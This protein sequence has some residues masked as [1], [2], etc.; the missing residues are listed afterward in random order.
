MSRRATTWLLTVALLIGGTAVGI[1]AQ[2]AEEDEEARA[3]RSE[4]QRTLEMVA[5]MVRAR[6]ASA[7]GWLGVRVEDVDDARAEEL[8][9]TGP[10]GAM[11]AGVEEESPAAEA[12]LREGDVIVSFDGEAVR[13]VAELV[14]LVRE[15]PTGRSVP[16]EVMRD[17]ERRSLSATVGDRPGPRAFRFR[18]GPDGMEDVELRL[19][20]LGERLS[21]E[22]MARV[23]ER[24]ERA[25]ERAREHAE[26]FEFDLE[27]GDVHVFR[28]S[29]RPR[30][31]VQLQSLTDQLAEYFGVSERGG[32]L[33]SA[34]RDGSP[35]S[36]AGLRAGDVVV[37][38]DGEEIEDAGDLMRAV[39]EAE[40][41]SATVTVVRRGQER[42]ITVEL[43]EEDRAEPEEEGA[44]GRRAPA[45][46][47][48]PARAGVRSP[49]PAPP[50]AVPAPP[51]LRRAAPPGPRPPV[52]VI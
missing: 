3:E 26:D 7:G 47:P 30:L 16:V 44:T 52:I 35:A 10:R 21:G 39:R 5:P 36:A 24:V 13:S 28:V 20:R 31:G 17:G 50:R 8:G 37:A 2:E 45:G 14:R 1:R 42:E 41:G 15:T 49:R 23:H 4:R 34:V 27:D 43:P 38:F 9:L 46:P 40:A 6:L 19:E 25:M 22:R 32:V 51:V 18:V 29:A 11:V 33:I 48:A 12:G